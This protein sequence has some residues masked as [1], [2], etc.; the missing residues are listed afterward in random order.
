MISFEN[1]N[2][3]Q[4]HIFQCYV[5]F[6]IVILVVVKNELNMWSLFLF[7]DNRFGISIVSVLFA[8]KHT[9]VIF[10]F[11][12]FHESWWNRMILEWDESVSNGKKIMIWTL[13]KWSDSFNY[14]LRNP[15]QLSGEVCQGKCSK[16]KKKVKSFCW[17][18]DSPGILVVDSILISSPNFC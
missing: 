13:K 17:C 15:N 3:S 8:P 12:A 6:F 1:L 4:S 18:R 9:L 5:S 2:S 7:F 11:L 10:L 16:E 14:Y